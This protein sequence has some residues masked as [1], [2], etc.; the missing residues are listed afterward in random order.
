[1]ASELRFGLDEILAFFQELEDTR[2]A[3]N[4]KHP[5]AT[6]VVVAVI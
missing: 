2:S 1:M 3:L 4:R 6:V 5:L